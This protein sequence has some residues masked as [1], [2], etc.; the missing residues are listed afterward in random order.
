MRAVVTSKII[1]GRITDEENGTLHNSL[2]YQRSKINEVKV[3]KGESRKDPI[4][5][6]K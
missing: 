5:N 1:I 6:L 4:K 3:H 2:E